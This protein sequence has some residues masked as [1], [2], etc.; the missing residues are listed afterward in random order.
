M[1]VPGLSLFAMDQ[2]AR[3]PGMVEE[4]TCTYIQSLYKMEKTVTLASETI[5]ALQWRYRHSK[6]E[7]RDTCSVPASWARFSDYL[8]SIVLPWYNA[9]KCATS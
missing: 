5:L 3:S 4:L 9:I 7:L 2:V 8:G 6:G 1:A